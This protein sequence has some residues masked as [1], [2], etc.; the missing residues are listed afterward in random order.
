LGER[1]QRSGEAEAVLML[2]ARAPVVRALVTSSRWARDSQ[3]AYRNA[4]LVA[5]R[6]CGV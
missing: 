4:N 6:R 5:A 1:R 2:V 3:A